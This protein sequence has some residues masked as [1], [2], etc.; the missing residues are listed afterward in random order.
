M[1]RQNQWFS[2]KVI[3]GKKIANT[4][5]F[6]TINLDNPGLLTGEKEG[7]YACLV[8]IDKKLH[9]GVLYFGPRLILGEQEK[10]LEI[11][12]FDFDKIIY[13]QTI[14]FMLKD[15]IRPVKNFPDFNQFKKQLASDCSRAR[16][17]LLK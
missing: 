14:S 1:A 13:G 7:V 4:L 9:K 2:A 5:G 17:I 10:I 8:K 6:P 15:Y 12:L 11:Y 16:E 3:A